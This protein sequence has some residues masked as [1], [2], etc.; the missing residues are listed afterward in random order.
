MIRAKKLSD[1]EFTVCSRSMFCVLLIL[2]AL[3]RGGLEL[4]M[5]KKFAMI[6]QFGGLVAIS[7][8][9]FFPRTC[10]FSSSQKFY[11]A[12][13]L[14]FIAE[15]FLSCFLT[16]TLSDTGIWIVYFAF[17][18]GLLWIGLLT[19]R[20][21]EKKELTINIAPVLLFAGWLLFAVA[22]LEMLRLIAFDATAEIILVRPASLTGSF[23]HYPL[24]IVLLGLLSLQW[25]A[26]SSKKAYLWSGLIFCLAPVAA[27]SRSGVL[28]FLASLLFYPFAAP[29]QK[30]KKIIFLGALI[31]AGSLFALVYFSKENSRSSFHK[32]A[33][34]IVTA[35]SKKSRGNSVR[36]KIW[37]QVVSEWLGTNLLIGEKAGKYTNASKNMLAKNK[38]G[39]GKGSIS[40]SSVLQ[41]LSNFGL[42][43]MVLF[44]A[45]LLQIPRFIHS[46]HYWMRA[47]FYASLFQT[48]FYQSVEVVPFMTLLF[49]FPFISQS[50]KIHVDKYFFST[51][52]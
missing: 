31:A 17:N 19:I 13:A 16:F 7:T 47:A 51:S 1:L 20:W 8:L 12:F 21:F 26:I 46:D 32:H 45:I 42:I 14:L 37:N 2:I 29:L 50:Y 15:S 52:P 33:R 27:A 23:L 38:S 44:Y 36:I 22:A 28:I 39:A 5:A 9:L 11:I 40:E 25:Y 35:A 43:G 49:L 4:A 30:S 3:C 6:A 34:H 24:I 10:F 48:L 41:L 18:I